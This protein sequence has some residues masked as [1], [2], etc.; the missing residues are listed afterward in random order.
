[1]K[2]KEEEV[3]ETSVSQKMLKEKEHVSGLRIDNKFTLIFE[4]SEPSI[5]PMDNSWSTLDLFL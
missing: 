5:N 3:R 1:M 2:K 4:T